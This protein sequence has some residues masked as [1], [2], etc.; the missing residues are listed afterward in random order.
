MKLIV[1]YFILLGLNLRP[2]E[3]G[4]VVEDDLVGTE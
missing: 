2:I 3:A 1:T 4:Q